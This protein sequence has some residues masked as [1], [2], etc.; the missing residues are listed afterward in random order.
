MPPDDGGTDGEVAPDVIAPVIAMPEAPMLPSPV[1]M[2]S[3][4]EGWEPTDLSGVT[5]CQPWA[6]DTPD[7]LAPAVRF[8]G[9]AACADVGADVCVDG[10]PTDV[11]GTRVVYVDAGAT[12]G[13]GSMA[14]P[15]ATIAEATAVAAS[16]E[17]IALAPGVYLE[18]VALPDGVSLQGACASTTIIESAEGPLS[19]ATVV[20]GDGS[21]LA[22]L[23]LRGPRPG[24]RLDG[25]SAAAS[26]LRIE[27]QHLGVAIIHGGH[28][29]GEDLA[30]VGTRGSPGGGLFLLSGSSAT[31]D[32]AY[33][34]DNQTFGVGVGD[35]GSMLTLRHA[36]IRRTALVDMLGVG[37]A[38]SG[39]ATVVIEES[40]ISENSTGGVT[41][42]D[43]MITLRSVVIRDTEAGPDGLLGA[44]IVATGGATVDIERSL[45]ARNTS[46]ALSLLG[47]RTHL[48]GR[49]VVLLDTLSP[50]MGEGLVAGIGL[51]L[52][53]GSTAELTRTLV[54]GAEGLGV[55]VSG[56]D[57]HLDATDLTVRN[58]SPRPVDM[59]AGRGVDVEREASANL[60]RL[61]VE[62]VYGSALLAAEVGTSI[63]LT[64]TTLRRVRSDLRTR[65][66]GRGLTMQFGGTVEASR[67]AIEDTRDVGILAY[68]EGVMLHATDLSIDRTAERECAVDTCMDFRSGNGITASDG[69]IADIQ[70]FRI[71][72]SNLV[73][74]Q[75]ARG[76]RVTARDGLVTRNAV[77]VNAQTDGFDP[78]DVSQNVQFIDNGINFDG[79]AL[80]I[81]QPG[82][83]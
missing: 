58:I 25:V 14:A 13:D 80:P 18:D 2:G 48:T 22:D 32:G 59:A 63:T 11:S 52:G 60:T 77:G 76:S 29:D 15:F 26:R 65:S 73:G 53:D 28:L 3:C 42:Q 45:V 68:G 40:E 47:L 82:M 44:G 67:L 31:V 37:V 62:D 54:D 35:F 24:L 83:R 27:A 16:G 43:G 69:A 38:V 71:A 39:P 9:Q 21:A 5:A 4:P 36:V 41:A 49:D 72:D 66:T 74:L 64:D 78:M 79:S 20:A 33:L 19:S 46:G 61:L 17:T 7:C 55:S 50:T 70:S 56:L 1:D 6:P 8:P 30:I 10:F 34:D 75:I 12:S 57:S 81:P 51:I 23:T